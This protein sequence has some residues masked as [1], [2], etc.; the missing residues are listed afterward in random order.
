MVR[1]VVDIDTTYELAL[2]KKRAFGDDKKG[3]EGIR[4]SQKNEDRLQAARR[5]GET[6]NDTLTRVLDDYEKS[7]S[8]SDSEKCIY[9]S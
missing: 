8:K 2:G 6:F 9:L 1:Q 5:S 7:R 4:I 3:R